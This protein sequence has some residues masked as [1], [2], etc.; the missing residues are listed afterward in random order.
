MWIFSGPKLQTSNAVVFVVLL[1]LINLAHPTFSPAEEIKILQPDN[2]D[3]IESGTRALAWE[4]PSDPGLHLSV[5]VITEE[6]DPSSADPLNADALSSDTTAVE[7]AAIEPQG[8]FWYAAPFD[9]DEP[10]GGSGLFRLRINLLTTN[11]GEN[12]EAIYYFKG[13][14][15]ITGT[16]FDDS[17]PSDI[18]FSI[19]ISDP[20]AGT[21]SEATGDYLYEV[22]AEAKAGKAKQTV[23]LN[24]TATSVDQ[25][26]FPDYPISLSP[27]T[28]DITFKVTDDQGATAP[29]LSDSVTSEHTI[30][31]PPEV[32]AEGT[33]F[34]DLLA[35]RVFNV[36]ATPSTQSLDLSISDDADEPVDIA[37]DI[38]PNGSTDHTD[39]WTPSGGTA[40]GHIGVSLPDSGSYAPRITLTDNNGA[41]GTPFD[42]E[43]LTVNTPPQ[44]T[45]AAVRELPPSRIFSVDSLP[46]TKT[47]DFTLLDDFDQPVDVSVDLDGDDTGDYGPVQVT[48]SGGGASGSICF[49]L[50]A[51][52]EYASVALLISDGYDFD[53]DAFEIEP[54]TVNIGEAAPVIA[55]LPDFVIGDAESVTDNYFVFDDAIDLR[56]Y[57]SDEDT[58]TSELKWSYVTPGGLG[59][60]TQRYMINGVDELDLDGS[61]P[62]PD[63]DPAEPGSK[64]IQDQVLQNEIDR[65]NNPQ[66][67]T[68]R[69]IIQTPYL[70]D[71]TT[72]SGSPSQAV[73]FFVADD[74]QST[75]SSVMMYTEAGYDRFATDPAGE[76]RTA[77]LSFI[78][79]GSGDWDSDTISG[80]VD[81]TEDGGICL[82]V[83]TT[84]ENFGEWFSG[85]A[86]ISLVQNSVWRVRAQVTSDVTTPGSVPLWEMFIDNYDSSIDGPFGYGVSQF[87]LDNAGSANAA[88]VIGR[89]DFQLWFTPMAMGTPQWDAF[90]WAGVDDIDDM[91]LHFR[92]LDLDSNN[93]N[94]QADAGTLCMSRLAID[95]FDLADLSVDQTVFDESDGFES[96]EVTIDTG[97]N[98]N[99]VLNGGQIEVDPVHPV[100]GFGN[101]V[102]TITP[103]TY[104]DA[105]FTTGDGLGDNYVVPW[106]SEVLYRFRAQW[107]ARS[108]EANP[109]DFYRMGLDNPGNELL[110]FSFTS[111]GLG[112]PF[113]IPAVL[114]PGTPRQ[115]AAA[116]FQMFMYS[117]SASED[118]R[119]N[120][121]RLRPRIDVL[122]T[123]SVVLG[124]VQNATDGWEVQSIIVEKVSFPSSP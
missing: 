92:V 94:S 43:S 22:I 101:E 23:S 28:Y 35:G 58:T 87:L 83:P 69:D 31:S 20:D 25:N 18:Q 30:N 34:S 105:N 40:S 17:D 44:I 37:I 122:N 8:N 33:G 68:I 116:D 118:W 71:T 51:S 93:I 7:L 78:R 66:T 9:F 5:V 107:Q 2:G 115:G 72:P 24:T 46:V 113:A 79:D 13:R 70:D 88:G 1:F 27:G 57:V 4:F 111:P 85:D 48:P 26:D 63:D 123:D 60:G 84:G 121:D 77:T 67:I 55:Q 103:G 102:V 47:I 109:S 100:A 99:A 114:P 11:F 19:D 95:R 50:A 119:N 3:E 6:L 54:F 112:N 29:G 15:E 62:G 38:E 74:V 65:D 76:E 16:T 97:A 80:S 90:E 53:G 117:H 21:D 89:T 39:S 42:I 108:G 96:D 104:E 106:E 86:Q 120:F 82:E 52:G 61:G 14:P 91:R 49:E 36:P 59:T 45:A 10:E 110:C 64:S 73:T 56:N 41:E 12:S 32:V 81:F 75:G 98:S 124:G